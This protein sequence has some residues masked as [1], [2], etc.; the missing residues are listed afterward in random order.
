MAEALKREVPEVTYATKV[1]FPEE[2]L[3]KVGEKSTKERGFYATKDFFLVFDY[4]PW[5]VVPSWHIPKSTRSL[6]AR[7]LAEVL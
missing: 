2:I 5:S 1:Q 7:K 4:P 3:V 6:S